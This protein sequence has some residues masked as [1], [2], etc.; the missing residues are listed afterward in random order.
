MVN[1]P[2]SKSNEQRND[3]L[4]FSHLS[5]IEDFIITDKQRSETFANYVKHFSDLKCALLPSSFNTVTPLSVHVHGFES[6]QI[7]QQLKSINENRFKPF[8]A[9]IL[10]S[11]TKQKTF[12]NLLRPPSPEK[13][14]SIEDNIEIGENNDDQEDI[15]K[16][17]NKTPKKKKKS[18]TFFDSHALN[19]FLDEQDIQEISKSNRKPSEDDDLEFDDDE[20]NGD[21]SLEEEKEDLTYDEFFDPP[22]ETKQKKKSK[23]EKIEIQNDPIDFEENGQ[24]E[25]DDEDDE[26]DVNLENKSDFEKQQIYL[27]RQIK[28]IEKDML[29]AKPWQLAGETD[30]HKRPENSLLE[31]YL[32]YDRTT[33]LAPVITN[34]TTD[35]IEDLIKQRIRDRVFDDVERKKKPTDTEAQAYKK[36]IVLEHEKS[37]MSLAQVYEQEYLK[38]QTVMHL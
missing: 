5:K 9:A 38:K 23:Q 19:K 32:Q 28:Y 2:V 21:L 4:I 13:S 27:K 29:S 18:V 16:S 22:A 26:E 11:K 35:S 14:S 24:Q 33:R 30:S 36:E 12:G 25:E 34:E 31:E 10:K 3:D 7:Y 1:L 37:K 17:L 6:E 15:S 8:L 20:E